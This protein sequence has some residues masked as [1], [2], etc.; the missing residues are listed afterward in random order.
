[1]VSSR[2]KYY[3]ESTFTHK[4]MKSFFIPG[5][6][7]IRSKPLRFKN[8]E[9][10]ENSYF[11]NL[12]SQFSITKP[13]G[14]SNK[15]LLKNEKAALVA[16][17]KILQRGDNSFLSPE[18]ECAL[19]K[20][21]GF[22]YTTNSEKGDISP[23]LS[24]EPIIIDDVFDLTE[25]S[26]S[27]PRPIISVNDSSIF[28]S[29]PER[30]FYSYCEKNF[31]TSIKWLQ[32]QP[33]REY[34][35]NENYKEEI[36][37]EFELGVDFLYTPPWQKPIIIEILGPHH[38]LGNENKDLAEESTKFQKYKDRFNPELVDVYGI[39]VSQIENK[40]GPD[41]ELVSEMLKTPNRIKNK[42]VSN[43]LK[44]LW[45]IGA[46]QNIMPELIETEKLYNR[47]SWKI[48]INSFDPLT[49]F[50]FF[51]NMVYSVLKI[52]N[53]DNLLPKD[54]VF[55]REESDKVISF[56]RDEN[57]R[58][59]KSKSQKNAA[60]S[61]K[62]DISVFVEYENTYLE[63]CNSNK[64]F[65]VR[66]SNFPFKL[67]NTIGK[68][69]KPKLTIDETHKKYL[70][71]L[72]K[73]IF[74]KKQFREVQ[75]SAIKNVLEGL[76]S[77]VLLPTGFG[78]SMIY[79]LASFILPGVTIIIS[80]TVAL[81]KNQQENLEANSITRAVGLSGE[82]DPLS[83]D[84][85][86]SDISSGDTF[87][88]LCSPERLLSP[89]FTD[90]M[91]QAVSNIGL[92]L[93]TIDEAHC[94][95]EW[96]QEFRTA[97]LGIG[98]R[99]ASLSENR[100]PLLAV[101]GTA[102]LKVRQDI[103]FNCS[104]K[105]NNVLQAQDYKRPELEFQVVNNDKPNDRTNKLKYFF[106]KSLVG[107]LSNN[108]IKIFENRKNETDNNLILIFVPYKSHL[109]FLR[110]E[111]NT[112]FKNKNI[113]VDIGMMWG[114]K[115]IRK[116]QFEQAGVG[117]DQKAYKEISV[118]DFKAGRKK[119]MIAT[120]AFGMGIDIPNIRSVVHYGI[121]SSLM[122]WYQ[123]AGRGGRDQEKSLCC[124]IYT[125]EQGIIPQELFTDYDSSVVEDAGQKIGESDI[126][127]TIAFPEFM[128]KCFI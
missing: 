122:S 28:D 70:E 83:R 31:P 4:G 115:P 29:N 100:V 119:I 72:L 11:F 18:V 25:E 106:D 82:D 109:I 2:K 34:F 62:E 128:K 78:K 51:L 13:D 76:S 24:S 59:E 67:Q 102:S 89:D 17:R 71:E 48:K 65:Y 103:I 99:L 37:K 61:H 88:I 111:L 33:K 55:F 41:F 52:W 87:I 85:K 23:I 5:G 12:F 3:I 124:T 45:S 77:L 20:K 42:T 58:Y 98:D 47:K 9:S 1:M 125:E 107:F 57:G 96:G 94:I 36:A 113:D 112:F 127:T 95:S 64:A 91:K 19:L 116:K 10:L 32:P 93:N 84:L 7:G 50:N 97:Y 8:G 38:F 46:L 26:K 53:S 105:E 43:F 126:F 90:T 35:V 74:G 81:I 56:S 117:E 120:K 80:P 68:V 110:K 21:Y 63:K 40:S 69:K 79:Q 30:E 108:L 14:S 16:L 73:Y 60:F 75:F 22:E 114:T 123:E 54:I 104:L 101:T 121:P 44:T 15:K 49:G 39:P 118:D 27:K 86:Y 6:V 66:K 92:S